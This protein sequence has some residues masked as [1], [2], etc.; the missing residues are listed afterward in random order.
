MVQ[1]KPT[2]NAP[3]PNFCGH[4]STPCTAPQHL[5]SPSCHATRTAPQRLAS[6][7]T[8]APSFCARTST[9]RHCAQR[10]AT[11]PWQKL[12]NSSPTHVGTIEW[13]STHKRRGSTHIGHHIV[14]RVSH[15]SQSPSVL[16]EHQIAPSASRMIS[17]T[18]YC[19]QSITLLT[20]SISTH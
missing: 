15:Y 4:L 6:A 19:P 12:E 20:E 2:H 13:N 7:R 17:R 18:S 16:T 8:S 11:K 5:V 3:A 10:P 1:L 9:Q 14:Q